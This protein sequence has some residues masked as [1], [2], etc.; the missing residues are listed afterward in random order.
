MGDLP[1]VE[2]ESGSGVWAL[3]PT[4]SPV[5]CVLVMT[6]YL[7]RPRFSSWCSPPCP[8]QPRET[9]QAGPKATQT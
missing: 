7:D 4:L 5:P 9:T 3:V 6:S 2:K 8:S 1:G